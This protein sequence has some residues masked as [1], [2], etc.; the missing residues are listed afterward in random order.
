MAAQVTISGFQ[1][2]GDKLEKLAEK[3]PQDLDDAAKFAAQTWA[4]LAD[5]SAPKD[6]GKLSGS[7]S[8]AQQSK[9]VWEVDSPKEYSPFMEWGT[10]LRT[11]V[12]PDLSDYAA[13]FIGFSS[14]GGNV[15]ELIYAW[16]LRKG[17]PKSAQWPIFKSII[18]TGVRPHPFFFIHKPVIERQLIQDLN[19]M[20]EGL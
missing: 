2:F 12:P 10:K 8:T 20:L 11:N 14:G 7:I 13:Q 9:G 1:E 18:I 19:Q 16:V 3:F 4:Q 17:L 15:K 6:F 5:R